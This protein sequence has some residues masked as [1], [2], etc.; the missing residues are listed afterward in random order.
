ME[1]I[2]RV[3]VV[4]RVVRDAELRYTQSQTAVTNISVACNVRRKRGDQWEDEGHFF[5]AVIWGKTAESLSQYLTK[6]K[7]V[8]VEGELRQNRWEEQ[9]GSR[10]SKVEILVRKIQLLSYDE[11]SQ[12]RSQ[13]QQSSS[14][15][16]QASTAA[17]DA[18][19]AD[20]DDDIPF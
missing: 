6:G 3:I 19:P 7:R 12:P 17:P 15:S 18:I 14:R 20:F 13:G 9:D 8:A 1:D 11:D 4:G 10:R 5:D 2:N 16:Q